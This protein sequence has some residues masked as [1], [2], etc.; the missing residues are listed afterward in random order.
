MNAGVNA[1]KRTNHNH[2]SSAT[3]RPLKNGDVSGAAASTKI[4]PSHAARASCL[5]TIVRATPAA[6]NTIVNA[7]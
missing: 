1:S 7:K 2:P 5:L 3:G 6:P 4:P